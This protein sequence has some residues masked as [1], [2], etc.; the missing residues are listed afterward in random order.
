MMMFEKQH[1]EPEMESVVTLN[2]ET[3]EGVAGG[4]HRYIEGYD[5][6]S[7]IRTG[8]GREYRSI[9]VLHR[10][11]D[12][13]YLGNT[14]IDERGVVWYNVRYDGRDAWVSSMY[15]RKISY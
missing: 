9:G 1:A 12:V 5:G 11:E 2:E 13:R 14:A 6:K 15:T 4:K 3:L 8:P 7:N 10:G